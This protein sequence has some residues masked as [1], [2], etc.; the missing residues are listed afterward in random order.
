MSKEE[1]PVEDEALWSRLRKLTSARIGL[2]RSGISVPTRAHLDFQL[3]QA[4]ARDAV[5][6]PFDRP[7]LVAELSREGMPGLLLSSAAGERQRYL[8]RPDLGRVLDPE[9]VHRLREHRA[10]HPEPVDLAIVVADGLSALAVQRHALPF[11]CQ[12]QTHLN[13]TGWSL[14]PVCVVE[15]GRVALGD[16]IG[17]L[18]GARMLVMLIGE[19]PGLSSPDSMG[20]YF[21]YAP[22]PGLSDAN[23]NCISNVR[24]EGLSYAMAA[25]RLMYLMHEARRRGLSGVALKDESGGVRIDDTPINTLSAE[26]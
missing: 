15:Q 19:R 7:A 2:G 13:P 11:L 21:T 14:A 1:L 18:L 16:E 8:Q 9:S 12:L 4:R 5:H 22:A 17:A 3:A 23:R 6:L 26:P 25:Q 20:L 10:V 24:I